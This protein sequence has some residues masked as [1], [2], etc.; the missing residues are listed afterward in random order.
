MAVELFKVK[1]LENEDVLL[2]YYN[3]IF[4]KK[5]GRCTDP[6]NSQ[7]NKVFLRQIRTY[8]SNIMER[9]IYAIEEDPEFYF[10]SVPFLA[11]MSDL[12]EQ[13]TLLSEE[14]RLRNCEKV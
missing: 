6:I 1:G 11:K 7:V 12:Q 14:E 9:V 10:H 5:D 2:F 4:S 3:H 13:T 8:S